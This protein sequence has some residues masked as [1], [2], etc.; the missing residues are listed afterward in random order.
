M[1]ELPYNVHG[2]AHPPSAKIQ[3]NKNGIDLQSGTKHFYLQ[4]F[5]FKSIF[6][7]N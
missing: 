4:P 7:L 5:F 3:E 2:M 1:Y 6:A